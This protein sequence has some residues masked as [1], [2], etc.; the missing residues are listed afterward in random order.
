[1]LFEILIIIVHQRVFDFE[2]LPSLFLVIP[3]YR[4][5]LYKFIL[6]YSTRNNLVLKVVDLN[7]NRCKLTF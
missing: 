6:T 4:S 3:C 1:M 7:F 2:L 5:Q